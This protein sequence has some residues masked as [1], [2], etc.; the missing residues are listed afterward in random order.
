MKWYKVLTN[1]IIA[2]C[3]LYI[4]I[5]FH[6]LGHAL[7]YY[8]YGCKLKLLQLNVPFYFAAANPGLINQNC[9]NLLC[10]YQLVWASMG[11]II[12]NLILAFGMYFVLPKLKD[13]PKVALFAIIFI[14]SNLIE[15][16]SYLTLNNIRPMGDITTV[17]EYFPLLRIPLGLVGVGLIFVIIRFLK[18]IPKQ[19][20][21]GMIIFCIATVA[22]MFGLRFLFAT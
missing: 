4:V 8:G 9:C 5:W 1:I 6:E 15:A 16:S 17:A 7:F 20:R 11:G 13:Y 12:A 22:F 21:K 3:A 14:L 19:L 10:R 2:Y 18:I